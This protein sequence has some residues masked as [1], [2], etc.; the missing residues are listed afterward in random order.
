MHHEK[1]RLKTPKHATPEISGLHASGILDL[2]LAYVALFDRTRA[3][4]SPEYHAAV[5]NKA[6]FTVD[7]GRYYTTP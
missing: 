1:A 2:V 6:A 4:L 7:Y 3:A 5:T